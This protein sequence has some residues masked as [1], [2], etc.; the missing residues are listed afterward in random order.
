MKAISKMLCFVA[1][2]TLFPASKGTAA[3]EK[4]YP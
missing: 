2:I 3:Q 1:A 4:V